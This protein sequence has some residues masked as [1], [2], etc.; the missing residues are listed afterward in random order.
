MIS[1]TNP[2][3]E[4]PNPLSGGH[5]NSLDVQTTLTLK[6]QLATPPKNQHTRHIEEG[7]LWYTC[8]SAPHDSELEAASRGS[9][10]SPV[11]GD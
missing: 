1:Q 5:V 11:K 2:E 6:P 3:L 8:S 7:L 10:L 4:P 9:Q